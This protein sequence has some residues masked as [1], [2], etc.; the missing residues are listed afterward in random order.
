MRR[1]TVIAGSVAVVLAG[2]LAWQLWGGR[3]RDV[4]RPAPPAAADQL[5]P[6]AP[7]ATSIEPAVPVVSD[8]STADGVRATRQASSIAVQSDPTATWIV[9]GR[10]LRGW[11]DPYPSV[12]VHLLLFEGYEAAGEP[13]QEVHLES[14]ADG[15][16]RWPLRPPTT[17]VTLQ[18]KGDEEG[19]YSS[20]ETAIV[21][22]GKP[23]PSL[24]VR[25]YPKDCEITGVVR[26][27]AGQPIM[28]VAVR[29]SGDETSSGDDGR[30]RIAA[31]SV[32]GGVNVVATASGYAQARVTAQLSGPGSSA[33]ANLDLVP[34][35]R[36]Q[37]RVVD[38]SG[39]P[40]EGAAV[41]SFFTGEAF[42]ATNSDGHFLLDHLDPRR[43][44]H[45][46]YARKEGYCEAATNVEVD[47][48]V[49]TIPDLILT[50]GVRLEGEVLD[51][52]SFRLEAVAPGPSV[53]LVQ[54]PPR[55][56][57]VDGPFEVPLT[58]SIDRVVQLPRGTTLTG[59]LLDANGQPLARES[60][61]LHASEVAGVES[62]YSN[63]TTTD[64]AGRFEFGGLS[65]GLYQV[66]HSVVDGDDSTYVFT[67]FVRIG[68]GGNRHVVLQP[69]GDGSIT[70]TIT[71]HDGSTVSSRLP[72]M[73]NPMNHAA[74][75]QEDGPPGRGTLAHDGRFVI[76]GISPGDY[77]VQVF[78]MNSNHRLYG[79]AR[80]TVSHDQ[81]AVRIELVEMPGRR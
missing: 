20:G 18:G 80:V 54:A 35:F 15:R 28:G 67:R 14:D 42:A 11:K 50:R 60:I 58:G 78:L 46:V 70:G 56:L 37:G 40:V 52:G 23:P 12:G 69:D 59:M 17:T 26:D 34:A 72:V 4:S 24:E 73:C 74:V 64:A 13:L 53:L 43:S 63:K 38:E 77:T 62:D 5:A 30:Y 31:S 22:A 66:S 44:S 8:P 71:M 81:Q 47:G 41:R 6:L 65:D 55:P 57:F 49:R 2:W 29:G 79:N 39:A 7:S 32:R 61:E 16:F 36:I 68:S 51:D 9:E 10:T 19:H 25:L 1:Q 3:P 45:S 76:D 21:V 48:E 27:E 33:I 75:E